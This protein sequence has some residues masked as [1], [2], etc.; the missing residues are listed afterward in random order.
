[1]KHMKSTSQGNYPFKLLAIVLCVGMV[2]SLSGCATTSAIA[3]GK[4]FDRVMAA[5]KTDLFGSDEQDCRVLSL[6]LPIRSGF[7]PITDKSAY[8]SL[9]DATMKEVYEKIEDSIY[10]VSSEQDENRGYYQ[11][12]YVRLPSTLE[13]DDIYIVKEAVLSDHP[14]AFWVLGSYDIRNNFHDGN[15]LVLYSKYSY[16]EITD[17]FKEINTETEH[18]LSQIPDN[19]DEWER[20]RIIHDALVDEVSYDTDA[21]ESDDSTADAFNMYGALVK[22]KA[23]CSG[24]AYAIK[25]LLNRVGIECRTVVGM[26][27]NSGH[28]WNQ[29]KINDNWYH[30]DATWDDSPS[31][32]EVLYSRYNYF[33]LTDEMVEVNHKIGKNYSEM[34]YEYTD[35]G[36]YTTPELYN[37]DLEVCSATE[38]NYYEMNAV[39][40]SELNTAAV[41]EITHKMVEVSQNKGDLVYMI[42][43][44][45][46]SSDQAELW[47]AKGSDGGYPAI[48]QSLANANKSGAGAKISK[49]ELMRMSLDEDS[50]WNNLY[51]VR[52]VYA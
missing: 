49:G 9:T 22:K 36:V 48:S 17:A 47:L 19:A 18:I 29:V 11:L 38:A 26:S 39:H 42:F 6:S 41:S 14:E 1:M 16:D 20:E 2:L 50:I 43:D 31:E 25:M 28:M 40:I 34:E 30:L 8:H 37:F 35:E 10:Q 12:K 7:E 52:L 24:Y 32:S 27:K 4:G 51:V 15:Y 44:S 13:F 23:V 46:I 45:A 33:N 21:A 3:E 5:V